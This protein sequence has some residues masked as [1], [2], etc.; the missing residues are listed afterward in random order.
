MECLLIRV[1]TVAISEHDTGPS[2][3]TVSSELHLTFNHLGGRAYYFHFSEK[4]RAQYFH[5]S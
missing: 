3:G 5:G 2:M 4:T 1:I